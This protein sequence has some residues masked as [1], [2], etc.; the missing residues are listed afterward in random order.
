MHLSWW[1]QIH[2]PN[3]QTLTPFTSCLHIFRIEIYLKNIWFIRI[4][5]EAAPADAPPAEPAPASAAEE[6][7]A[8]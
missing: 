6:A 3:I 1:S 4:I 8:S 5:A 2:F 7:P